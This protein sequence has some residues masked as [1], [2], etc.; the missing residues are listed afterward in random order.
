MACTPMTSHKGSL[1]RRLPVLG[2]V[3][4]EAVSTPVLSK[5]RLRGLD[6]NNAVWAGGDLSERPSRIG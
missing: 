1:G 3:W 4:L 2:V 6:K 5:D